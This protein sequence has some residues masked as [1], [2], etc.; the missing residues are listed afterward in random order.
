MILLFIS[1]I[2]LFIGMNE[3]NLQNNRFLYIYLVYFYFV[4]NSENRKTRY[5]NQDIKE[6]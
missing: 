6:F 3:V 4:I 5:L 1:F 2:N